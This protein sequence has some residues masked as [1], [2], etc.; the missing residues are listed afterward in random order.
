MYCVNCE[1]ISGRQELHVVGEMRNAVGTRKLLR[2]VPPTQRFRAEID[3]S[4]A[5]TGVIV[6]DVAEAVIELA[7]QAER[8]LAREMEN[9]G[10]RY[11]LLAHVCAC[12]LH[13][14]A[15]VEIREVSRSTELQV[16]IVA[17]RRELRCQRH[18]CRSATNDGRGPREP[19]GT[20]SETATARPCDDQV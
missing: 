15:L 11:V 20:G 16:D 4:V 18:C 3:D 6:R 14:D 17:F 13:D 7:G 9:R 5:F 8:R 10:A 19:S 1:R 2:C 12:S